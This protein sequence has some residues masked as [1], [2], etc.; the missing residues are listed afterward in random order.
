MREHRC[1]KRY[2]WTRSELHTCGIDGSALA[3]MCRE[4]E[5]HPVLPGI[6]CTRVPTT[7]DRCHAVSLWRPDAVM[8]HGTAAWLH[9]LLEE[10]SVI[11]AYVR[12]LPAELTPV[13]LQLRVPEYGIY[14]DDGTFG[15]DV[16]RPTGHRPVRNLRA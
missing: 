11:E 9:G 4:G 2:V 10:P 7:I 15:S 6:Y 14:H 5:L 13:W 3:E 8:S 1:V 16:I 12:Q